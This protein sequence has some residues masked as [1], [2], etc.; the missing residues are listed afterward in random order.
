[1]KSKTP[2][3]RLTKFSESSSDQILARQPAI[4]VSPDLQPSNSETLKIP[5]K[6]KIIWRFKPPA[7]LPILVNSKSSQFLPNEERSQAKIFCVK[8]SSWINHQSIYLARG[9]DE[10]NNVTIAHDHQ[11]NHDIF[12]LKKHTMISGQSINRLLMFAKHM[13]LINFD[14][15]F[16]KDEQLF[17]RYEMMNVTLIEIQCT[18]SGKLLNHHIAAICNDVCSSERCFY[19]VT[20]WANQVLHDMQYVHEQLKIAHDAINVHN[21]M[22]NKQDELKIDMWL[23]N[24]ETIS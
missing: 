13:N 19:A 23:N 11:E 16:L 2:E 18:P 12:A 21:V 20:D 3:R 7:Q 10:P 14:R 15:I 6:A 22:V 4:V 5:E 24:G 1:M 8:Q 9:H 17:L